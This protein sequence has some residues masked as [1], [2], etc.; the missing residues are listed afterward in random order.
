[1]KINSRQSNYVNQQPNQ[2]L[3]FK[4]RLVMECTDTPTFDEG[5]TKVYNSNAK[6]K[7]SKQEALESIN[8]S[9]KQ[10]DAFDAKFKELNAFVSNPENVPEGDTIVL[11]CMLSD[12]KEDSGSNLF[13][14]KDKEG[15]SE[16]C[17]QGRGTYLLLKQLSLKTFNELN[18]NNQ[19]IP[20]IRKFVDEMKEFRAKN[21]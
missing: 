9:R 16:Q 7:I 2:N 6:K 5:G 17:M 11:N 8:F 18:L 19:L 13:G 12:G 3:S 21:N 20:N 1:M 14:Y 15:T 4:G 10:V